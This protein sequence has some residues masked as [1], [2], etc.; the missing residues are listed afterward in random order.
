MNFKRCDW[1]SRCVG[2][3]DVVGDHTVMFFGDGERIEVRHHG[4]SR[5]VFAGWGIYTS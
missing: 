5:Q 4:H 3:G 1:Y 2:G